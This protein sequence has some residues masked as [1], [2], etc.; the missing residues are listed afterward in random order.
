MIS[1]YLLLD[2]F[3]L[4]REERSDGVRPKG[5]PCSASQLLLKMMLMRAVTSLTLTTP[6]P[7]RSHTASL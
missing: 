3:I 4:E 5:P 6:S 2:C 1:V 7:L